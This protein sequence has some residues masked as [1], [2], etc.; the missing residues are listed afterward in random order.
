[1]IDD[2]QKNK[3]L[4]HLQQVEGYIEA[5]DIYVGVNGHGHLKYIQATRVGLI[6]LGIFMIQSAFSHEKYINMDSEDETLE[7]I[8]PDETD[9]I[10]YIEI[11]ENIKESITYKENK[12][13]NRHPSLKDYLL[14]IMVLMIIAII[15][16]IITAIIIGVIAIIRQII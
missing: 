2:D 3:L 7:W 16:S 13:D 4:D 1:M 5:E 14:F 12:E 11:I 8:D 15:V 9:P 10:H 6:K